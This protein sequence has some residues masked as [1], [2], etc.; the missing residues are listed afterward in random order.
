LKTIN[1]LSYVFS[2]LISGVITSLVAMF[3]MLNINIGLAIWIGSIMENP[4]IGFFIV[5]AFYLLVLLSVM[6]IWKKQLH[7]FIRNIVIKELID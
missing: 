1:K 2:N 4:Y 6:F 3:L 7:E 5:A